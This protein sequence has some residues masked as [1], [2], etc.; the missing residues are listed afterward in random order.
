MTGRGSHVLRGEVVLEMCAE[1]W[2][3]RRGPSVNQEASPFEIRQPWTSRLQDMRKKSLMLINHSVY[4]I[5][6]QQLDGLRQPLI[7]CSLCRTAVDMALSQSSLQLS[8]IVFRR[9]NKLVLYR[10]I[11]SFTSEGYYIL[12]YSYTICSPLYFGG[13]LFFPPL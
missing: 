11:L 5:L 4:C 2:V 13:T 6:L 12:C 1:Q 10:S 3:R 7:P 9:Q 8:E